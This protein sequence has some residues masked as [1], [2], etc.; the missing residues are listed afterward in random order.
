MMKYQNTITINLENGKLHICPNAEGKIDSIIT[1]KL[2]PTF[3]DPYLLP[4]D[5][6]WD[7]SQINETD[8][9]LIF[10]QGRQPLFWP[11]IMRIFDG[12]QNEKK[13]I[14]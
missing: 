5:F 6:D 9:D 2:D 13:E 7:D 11:T 14:G 3:L 12:K 8:H 10:N 4:E 1:E